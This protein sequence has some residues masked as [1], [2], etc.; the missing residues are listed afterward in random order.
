MSVCVRVCV[1]A[2]EC[3]VIRDLRM[4][5]GAASLEW[6]IGFLRDNLALRKLARAPYLTVYIVLLLTLVFVCVGYLCQCLASCKPRSPPSQLAP[7]TDMSFEWFMR[8]LHGSWINTVRRAKAISSWRQSIT[9][10]WC[11]P[12]DSFHFGWIGPVSVF[13]F[14]C[15][16]NF[17]NISIFPYLPVFCP[18][19]P[20]STISRKS[21]G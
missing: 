11:F 4:R 19:F 14:V 10:F 2:G 5:W 15:V 12:T 9:L 8:S 18:F 13:I 3:G 6:Q 21:L 20:F 1:T 7:L 16:D 17:N